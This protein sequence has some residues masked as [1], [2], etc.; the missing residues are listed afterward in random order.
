MP[1]IL[2]AVYLA[3]SEFIINLTRKIIFKFYWVELVNE[4]PNLLYILNVKIRGIFL[5]VNFVLLKTFTDP[6]SLF[7]IESLN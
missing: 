2:E 1:R 5:D 6:N 4:V 7:Q 3:K